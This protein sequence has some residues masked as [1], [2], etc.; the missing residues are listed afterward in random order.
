MIQSVRHGLKKALKQHGVLTR[1]QVN[2]LLW[3]KLPANY[4]EDRKNNK[5]GN[6]L[7][8][9]RKKGL[10]ICDSQKKWRLSEI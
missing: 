6:L 7:T 3:H 1:K 9:F 8:K 5:I 4:D 2:E 10:I